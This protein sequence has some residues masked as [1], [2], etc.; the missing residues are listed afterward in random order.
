M[1]S[2]KQ[3]LEQE[4]ARLKKEAARPKKLHR[5]ASG[6]RIADTVRIH[7][8]PSQPKILRITIS[9]DIF[10][11]LWLWRDYPNNEH[12][13]PEKIPQY[14]LHNARAE[15]LSFTDGLPGCLL[16][17][18]RMFNYRPH[19]T[20]LTRVP[21]AWTFRTSVSHRKL[22]LKAGIESG[23]VIRTI[24]WEEQAGFILMFEPEDMMHK[25]DMTAEEF[26]DFA[27]TTAAGGKP[28]RKDE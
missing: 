21:K 14:V 27:E 19:G 24:P 2:F 8:R 10:R 23:R 17:L 13:A 15:F 7:C 20:L 5:Y 6:A 28:E 1:T 26:A 22:G 25:P 9:F 11:Q 16:R 12:K 3:E 4:V 18:E